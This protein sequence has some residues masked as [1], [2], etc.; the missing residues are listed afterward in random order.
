MSPLA[1]KESRHIGRKEDRLYAEIQW[2]I[3]RRKPPGFL[4]ETLGRQ[5][6]KAPEHPNKSNGSVGTTTNVTTYKRS[7][8]QGML[9]YHTGSTPQRSRIRCDRLKDRQYLFPRHKFTPFLDCHPSDLSDVVDTVALSGG[10]PLNSSTTVDSVPRGR[11]GR[12]RLSGEN[13]SKGAI[14]DMY[15]KKELESTLYFRSSPL[16]FQDDTNT[17]SAFWNEQRQRRTKTGCVRVYR[18]LPR[19]QIPAVVV[20]MAQTSYNLQ[21]LYDFRFIVAGGRNSRIGQWS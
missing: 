8:S 11:R 15:K 6:L 19:D 14:K 3:D 4:S 18:Y 7:L 9:Q 12:R 1:T 5:S 16:M 2:A 10:F 17:P 21:R 20:L 13:I